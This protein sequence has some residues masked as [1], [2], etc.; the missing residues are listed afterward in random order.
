MN[1]R[2][3]YGISAGLIGLG[4]LH[5]LLTPMFYPDFSPNAVWFAGSG[6]TLVFLGAINVARLHSRDT[7][8]RRMCLA[9][10]LTGTLFCT[11]V[12]LAVPE[13]Q[14]YLA[15]GLAAAALVASALPP[16]AR[17]GIA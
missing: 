12:A 17:T 10:N 3:D 13:P 2:I 8:L 4:T 15:V 9:A 6:L 14:A 5:T 1:S 11:V 7:L 16:A